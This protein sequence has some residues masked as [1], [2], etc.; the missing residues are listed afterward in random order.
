MIDYRPM[1]ITAVVAVAVLSWTLTCAFV[2]GLALRYRADAIADDTT[3]ETANDTVSSRPA[4]TPYLT[5]AVFP[6][7]TAKPSSV[8]CPVHGPD[9]EGWL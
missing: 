7:A 8:D 1:I 9:C 6:R 2:L 5:E 3:N 4:Y